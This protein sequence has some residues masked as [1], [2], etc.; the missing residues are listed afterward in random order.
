MM[1]RAGGM[2]RAALFMPAA[3]Y[4]DH[5]PSSGGERRCG[6]GVASR[7][8]VGRRSVLERAHQR[9][10]ERCTLA[11]AGPWSASAS[12]VPL[13]NIRATALSESEGPHS[14][15]AAPDPCQRDTGRER[16]PQESLVF[17]VEGFFRSCWRSPGVEAQSRFCRREQR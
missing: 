17:S 10:S 4:A 8:D 5:D 1:P 9:I 13:R 14:A 3:D 6:D 12:L 7:R 11:A 16:I 2:Q 15:G